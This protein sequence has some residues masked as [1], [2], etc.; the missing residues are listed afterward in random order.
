MQA[1]KIFNRKRSAF[2]LCLRENDD[3]GINLISSEH[4]VPVIR[5]HFPEL[6]Q[7]SPTSW[8]RGNKNTYN[9]WIPENRIFQISISKIEQWAEFAGN[10]CVWL[11]KGSQCFNG[12]EV[13][14]CIVGDFNFIP[15]ENSS[16]WSRS[17]LGEAEYQLKYHMADL[18]QCEIQQYF[19]LMS[20]S[21]LDMFGLLPLQ[22]LQTSSGPVVSPVPAQNGPNKLA[23]ALAKQV[24]QSTGN[25][26]IEPQLR[27]QKPQIKHLKEEEKLA[28]W[29]QAYRT[30]NAVALP[31]DLV[32]GKDVIV[33]D[34]LYQ[35]G[36]TLWTY[37]KFLKD[38]GARHV[39]GLVCVK[40]MKDSDNL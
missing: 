15:S 36:T 37:A 29:S 28:F 30:P 33:V 14:Y 18:A 12:S 1:A 2:W 13:D 6:E 26:F 20:R 32:I 31:A 8:T 24:A 9:I 25:V 35:S 11:A 5:Y 27:I 17:A 38:V 7:V 39:Y 10:Q 3:G 16:D 23:W 4:V 19:E 34:D 22:S 21:L 40:S